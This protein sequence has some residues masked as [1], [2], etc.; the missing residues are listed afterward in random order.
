MKLESIF[1]VAFFLTSSSLS[2]QIPT[3]GLIAH[4]SFTGNTEDESGNNFHGMNNGA[5]LTEDRC[6]N[7]N[8]A[9]FFDGIDDNIIVLDNEALRPSNISIVFWA[10]QISFDSEWRAMVAKIES[11]QVF[12]NNYIVATKMD[13]PIHT[14]LNEGTNCFTSD[15]V[16]RVSN[17]FEWEL[18]EWQHICVTYDGEKIHFYQNGVV[19]D[20]ASYEYDIQIGT[21]ENAPL[22]IGGTFYNTANQYFEGALDEIRIYDYALTDEEVLNIYNAESCTTNTIESQRKKVTVYPNP[23]RNTLFFSRPVDKMTL[24]N[25]YGQ[26]VWNGKNVNEV[27]I[28]KVSEGVYFTIIYENGVQNISKVLISN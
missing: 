28:S 14:A 2:G 12:N 10:K 6:G 5:M 20:T 17:P 19:V 8:S 13:R 23:A 7:E 1:L 26:A 3:D 22:T 18:D 4:Y 25:I 11:G 16:I 21:C 9:Y 24:V 15:D 27:D